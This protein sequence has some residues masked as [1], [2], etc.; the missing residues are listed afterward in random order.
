MECDIPNY[1]TKEIKDKKMQAKGVGLAK[2]DDLI[3]RI[4]ANIKQIEVYSKIEV[5]INI[6]NKTEVVDKTSNEF[7]KIEDIS[8]S[9][10]VPVSKSLQSMV[11]CKR[12][13]KLSL[14]LWDVPTY[15][16]AIHIKKAL[17]FYRKI[18]IHEVMAT[19]K[20]KVL[21]IELEPKDDRKASFL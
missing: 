2:Q 6:D 8:S 15:T 18:L 5:D 1:G 17:S 19:G 13:D 9:I 11:L 20:S 3:E 10:W 7:D 14:T 16:R 12:K 21:Y 4:I